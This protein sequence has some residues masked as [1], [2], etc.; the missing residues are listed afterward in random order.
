M[1][2]AGFSSPATAVFFYSS[3]VLTSCVC[4]GALLRTHKEMEQDFSRSVA[5]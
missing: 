5:M 1:V 4:K 2:V 3:I